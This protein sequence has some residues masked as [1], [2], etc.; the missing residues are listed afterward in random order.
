MDHGSSPRLFSRLRRV[1]GLLLALGS[2]GCALALRP[3]EVS[4][5]DLELVSVDLLGGEARVLLVV[6]NPNRVA[7][8]VREFSYRVEV[9]APAA[10]EE[11]GWITVA[12]EEGVPGVRLPPL[13]RTPV[14]IPVRF[15]LSGIGAALGSILA[16]GTLEYRVEG[17]LVGEGRLA[18]R[19]RPFR[20]QG[21]RTILEAPGHPGHPGIPET[22]GI[23]IPVTPA[24]QRALPF[25][26]S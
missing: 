15:R 18:G 9:R 13:T 23:R 7:L 1:A 12:E 3:P 14:Q 21:R 8:G 24:L 11:G 25:P 17:T 10:G 22:A 5:D 4:L 20:L 26:P 6:E 19:P 16:S 2:A